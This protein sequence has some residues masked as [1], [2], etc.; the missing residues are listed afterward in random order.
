MS[1]AKWRQF[2]LG[3]NVLN[4]PTVHQYI[5]RQT[6]GLDHRGTI[7]KYLKGLRGIMPFQ[8]KCACGTRKKCTLDPYKVSRVQIIKKFRNKTP[9]HIIEVVKKRYNYMA[10]AI[11]I[12]I[13]I[14]FALTHL[15]FF[16]FALKI[17]I[18]YVIQYPLSKP[19]QTGTNL[20][21]I[22]SWISWKI[23][24]FSTKEKL[25]ISPFNTSGLH[26]ISI[27]D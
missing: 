5:Y 8:W 18:L 20:H 9:Y 25:L 13:Y 26:T 27:L 7:R 6:C 14:S 2:C 17:C 21:R 10:N 3:L 11:N 23:V 24:K 16:P 4:W 22:A 1:S 19:K 15:Y 12:N